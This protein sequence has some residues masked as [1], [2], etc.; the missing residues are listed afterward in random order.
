MK[1]C[2]EMRARLTSKLNTMYMLV[3]CLGLISLSQGQ[4]PKTKDLMPEVGKIY[5]TYNQGRNLGVLD[6]ATGEFRNVGSY[7]IPESAGLS[8]TAF[9]PDGRLYGMLQGFFGRGGKSQLVSIDLNTG[10]AT[11]I[12]VANPLNAV[13]FDIALDGMAYTAG[14]KDPG[15]GME[16]DTVLYRVD[17]ATGQ[18]TAIGDTGIHRIMDFAFDSTGVMWATTANELYTVDT[19]TGVSQHVAHITGVDTATGNPTAQI[20]GIMFDD[21]DV[22]YATAFIQR[23]PLFTVDTETGAATVAAQ[24]S[25]T[26]PHGGAIY[27]A[28]QAGNIY[29]T[30]NLGQNLGVLNVI[31]GQFREVGS[32][33]LPEGTGLSATAFGPDGA[34]YGMLQGFFERGGMSQLVLIDP[35]TGKVAPLGFYNPLNAVGFDFAPDGT[36]YV[37]GFTNPDLGMEGDTILYSIDITTGQLTAIGDTGVERL[38]DFA[39]DSAGVMWATTA[40]ELYTI[41][42]STGT[43]QHVVSIKGVD[44]ATNDPAAEIMGIMFDEYDVLYA[45]AFIEG[46]PLFTIDT[47]TG[48]ATIEAEPGLSFPHGGAMKAQEVADGSVDALD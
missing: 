46:S 38:M 3:F 43:S 11:A 35:R 23:S 26:F 29:T 30:Y 48:V 20:M 13:G 31:T 15:L 1:G 32:Y 39:F 42:P 9:S 40:N 34:L 22:L 4:I 17:T 41:D 19:N 6:L 10:K 12:G 7:G 8:A 45:T 47:A 18:L 25:L 36:A 24:L 37:A 27:T 28:P 16:G 14:F 2:D 5:S 44:T 33:R 21:H